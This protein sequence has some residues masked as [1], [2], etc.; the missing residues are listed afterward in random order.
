MQQRTPV[1]STPL[2]EDFRRFVADQLGLNF[3]P[4]RLDDLMR[5]V[6]SA[7]PE[8]GFNGPA[9]CMAGLMSGPLNR[10]QAEVLAS[11]LTVGETY[12][13]REASSFETLE[14]EILPEMIRLRRDGQKT[15]RI[16]C[17]GCATGEE[18]YSVAM[19]LDYRFPELRDWHVSI[20]GTDINPGFLKKASSGLYTE[21]SFRQ[22]PD[23]AKTTFF[24]EVS[25]GTF[26]LAPHI[27]RQVTF[28]YLNLAEDVYPAVLNNTNAIDDR[29][30]L[31]GAE[32][33][34]SHLWAWL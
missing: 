30:R 16:W 15:L 13:F 24:K 22:T 25:G 5:G 14:R 10:E 33:L 17:A 34:R 11:H 12:F 28:A 32:S 23:W 19:L 2:A 4:E 21:W 26:E 29:P 27:R 6:A 3:P 31:A 18:P 9:Q 20:L 1:E 7:C 8:L